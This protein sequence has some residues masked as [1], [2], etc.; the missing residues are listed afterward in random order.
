MKKI[1]VSIL[2]FSG[3]TVTAAADNSAR[4][5]RVYAGTTHS[6]AVDSR[7]GLWCWGDNY[8]GQ[9]GNGKQTKYGGDFRILENNN[10][11]RPVKIMSNIA[12]AAAGD[13]FTLALSNTGVLYGWGNGT[14]VPSEIMNNVVY[15]EAHGNAAMI[16]K[17]DESLWIWNQSDKTGGPFAS[18]RKICDK[19]KGAA[20]G[21][22]SL[23]V[24]I[25]NDVLFVSRPYSRDIEPVKIMSGVREVSSGRQQFY[26]VTEDGT[27]YSW[28]SNGTYGLAGVGTDELMIMTPTYVAD[29][30]KRVIGNGGM[31]IKTD[32]SLWVWGR[33][34]V[35][36]EFRKAGEVV[37]SGIWGDL[38]TYGKSPVKILDNVTDACGEYH[39]LAV[40]ENG[41][42]FS[43]GGNEYGQ[44]G[45]GLN[46]VVER[47]EIVSGEVIDYDFDI[48]EKNNKNEEKPKFT[49][50]NLINIK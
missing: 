35:F 25:R 38:K 16:I 42:L 5:P 12:C 18:A 44:L 17:T 32:N 33:I 50:F 28:G 37:N 40:K 15:V 21:D 19:V 49:G 47:S 11:S 3:F 41:Q 23:V 43:W 45:N 7:G 20:L 10:A 6:V 39:Y 22:N 26:A 48:L 46:S 2:V 27:L 30:V 34:P 24:L 9:I 36:V 1:I 14:L 8:Y 29:N 13:G 31:L 4:L